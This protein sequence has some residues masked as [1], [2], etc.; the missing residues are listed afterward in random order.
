MLK[1]YYHRDDDDTPLEKVIALLSLS[2]E[3]D[4]ATVRKDVLKQLSR[5]YPTI[6]EEYES[7]VARNSSLFGRP[8]SECHFPLLRGVITPQSDVQ[9]ILPALFYSCTTIPFRK[10]IQDEAPHL[11]SPVLQTLLLGERNLN[12]NTHTLLNC[13]IVITSLSTGCPFK[14]SAVLCNT[15]RT[16][17]LW[18]KV[19]A[20]FETSDLL[21]VEGAD[22]VDA[23]FERRCAWCRQRITDVVGRIK[24]RAWDMIPE[25]FDFK[26]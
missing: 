11:P 21:A 9:I 25:C 1:S 13:V 3:Y 18:R 15:A 6:L 16:S 12:F 2:A 17:T 22:V 7:S 26:R 14:E 19:D 20:L 4:V 10:I 8:R 5:T 24:S 23:V